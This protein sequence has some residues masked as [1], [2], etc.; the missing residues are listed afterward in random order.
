MGGDA[1]SN[2]RSSEPWTTCRRWPRS[3][4]SDH[5][6]RSSWGRWSPSAPQRPRWKRLPPSPL[7]PEVPRSRATLFGMEPTPPPPPR[8]GAHAFGHVVPAAHHHPG[9]LPAAHA[10]HAVRAVAVAAEGLRRM[11]G[12]A[13]DQP[14]VVRGDV[15]RRDRELRVR[16][17]AAAPR[18]PHREVVRDRDGA[19]LR[20]RVQPDRA[21]RCGGRRRDPVPA[22]RR[23]GTRPDHDRYRP[24]RDHVHQLRDA[25]RAAGPGA[26]R[27]RVR[28][29]GPAWTRPVGM[30]RR[31]P[32]RPGDRRRRRSCSPP[33]G[34]SG[35]SAR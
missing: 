25:V 10:V 16:V 20:E 3:H 18:A 12:P 26:P 9:D 2:A 15:P 33:T 23:V 34:R 17:G 30:A 29:A 31:R 14:G 6:P 7:V 19:D 8:S 13:D 32:V 11:A 21:R 4:A 22:A 27:D 5:R 1:R 35:G 24:H 28:R